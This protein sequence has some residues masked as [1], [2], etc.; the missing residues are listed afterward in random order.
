MKYE[1]SNW[2]QDKINAN[3]FDSFCFYNCEDQQEEIMSSNYVANICHYDIAKILHEEKKKDHERQV[4]S[5]WAQDWMC[6]YFIQRSFLYHI[7]IFR[8]FFWCLHVCMFSVLFLLLAT[9]LVFLKSLECSSYNLKYVH[10]NSYWAVLS[11][12]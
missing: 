9:I 7:Q 3:I 11:A 8:F 6:I 1:S 4:L 5:K 10:R 2:A 12:Y